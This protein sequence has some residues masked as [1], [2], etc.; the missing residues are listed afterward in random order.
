M[1]RRVEQAAELE[2]AAPEAGARSS[3]VGRS[4]RKR[5]S[6]NRPIASASAASSR[7][8]AA[9]RAGHQGRR[10]ISQPRGANRAACAAKPLPS[11]A[12]SSAAGDSTQTTSN[13][14]DHGLGAGSRPPARP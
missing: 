14:A 3:A 7:P 5:R 11:S 13:S 1:R 9:A 6:R 10:T 12:G 4:E 8:H 2:I